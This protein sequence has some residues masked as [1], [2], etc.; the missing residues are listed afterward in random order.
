MRKGGDFEYEENEKMAWTCGGDFGT[1][2]DSDVLC[3]GV[4]KSKAQQ[5][6]DHIGGWQVQETEGKEY[7]KKSHMEQCKQKDCHSVQEW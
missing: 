5:Q 3:T 1:G 6:V 7:L 2:T 4:I